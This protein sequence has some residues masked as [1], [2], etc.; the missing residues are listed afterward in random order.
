MDK[1][2]TPADHGRLAAAEKKKT[3]FD[4]MLAQ[5]RPYLQTLGMVC[6]LLVGTGML[7]EAASA[8]FILGYASYQAYNTGAGGYLWATLATL[9]LLI[10]FAVLF[11]AR[12]VRRGS[13]PRITVLILFLSAISLFMEALGTLISPT[14]GP[15]VTVTT[16]TIAAGVVLLVALFFTATESTWVLLT[17]A[18]L[19]LV[20]VVLLIVRSS[21][22]EGTLAQVGG[23]SLNSYL[24]SGPTPQGTAV[25]TIANFFAMAG[26]VGTTSLVYIA[27]LIAALGLM[28]W[29]VLRDTRLAQLAWVTTLVG[30]FVYGI[31]MA[32]GNA[33]AL[34]AAEK[35]PIQWTTAA[36]PFTSAILLEVASF[37]IMAST[38]VGLVIHGQD[39]RA[40]LTEETTEEQAQA[41]AP[42]L[43]TEEKICPHCGTKIPIDSVYCKKC[44]TQLGSDW[45]S[46]GQVRVGKV[47]IICG[48]ENP[49][50]HDYCKKCG[51]PLK[52][53]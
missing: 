53:G 9:L 24:L 15:S 1:R 19:G 52:A 28:F 20:S 16:L 18:V 50:D 22:L 26:I 38:A 40:D 41:A 45:F 43:A 27:Y 4:L 47:C 10:S 32:W 51:S 34:A 14:L 36:L 33:S 25:A 3:S 37:V 17:A 11:A 5:L 29:S 2:R 21:D 48:A 49:S 6:L 39:L 12:S 42:T 30:F 23:T 31:D 13:F 7:L 44:G 46:A 35:G 8:Y